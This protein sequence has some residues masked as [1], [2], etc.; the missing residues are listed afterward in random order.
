MNDDKPVPPRVIPFRRPEGT[1]AP[2]T[3]APLPT[4]NVPNPPAIGT[5]AVIG[6]AQLLDVVRQYLGLVGPLTLYIEQTRA[7]AEQLRSGHRPSESDLELI[8][9]NAGNDRARVDLIREAYE[10]LAALLEARTK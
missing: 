3:P 4:G 1:D 2:P 7:L 6:P 5:P 8:I 9:T 10:Q